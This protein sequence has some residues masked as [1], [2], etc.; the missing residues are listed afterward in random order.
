MNFHICNVRNRADPILEP[1]IPALLN[2]SPYF[3]ILRKNIVSFE[4]SPVLSYKIVNEMC[5]SLIQ[6]KISN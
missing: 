6:I 2:I 5:D 1:V 3:D 4:Y